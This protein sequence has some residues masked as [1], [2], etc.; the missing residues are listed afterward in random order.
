[1]FHLSN[2]S[3]LTTTTAGNLA[4]T[5]T[6]AMATKEHTIITEDKA[7]EAYDRI[8]AK[9]SPQV[10]QAMEIWAPYKKSM[11]R[12]ICPTCGKSVIGTTLK[13]ELS[14]IEF[15]ISA[16]CQDCQDESHKKADDS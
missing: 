6:A 1:M 12:A 16:K 14:W 7:R 5:T 15:N 3:Q 9:K 11:E 4:T 2:N 8:R 10:L 13:N